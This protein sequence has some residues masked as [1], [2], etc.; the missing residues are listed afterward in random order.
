ML[1]LPMEPSEY[2]VV[3][4]GPGALLSSMTADELISQLEKD[5]Q[6]VSNIKGV[7]NHMGSEMT[8]HSAQMH[9]IFSILKKQGLYFI[10]SRT[11]P[12]T[13]CKP[14]ARMVHMPFAERD[15]FLDHIPTSDFIEN[16]LKK[17][18]RIAGQKGYAIGI[19]HPHPETHQVL[20]KMLPTLRKKVTLVPASQ[21][22]L[23]LNG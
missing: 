11:T 23:Q 19:G 8:Q 4:P 10:D 9:R 14:S 5:L 13:L 7:N 20:E 15:I 21:I 22:I 6:S 3:N 1:H 17:L 18:I 2:P 16:Q 12:K